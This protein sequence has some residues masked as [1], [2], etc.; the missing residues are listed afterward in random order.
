MHRTITV[1][2]VLALFLLTGCGGTEEK[3]EQPDS[4]PSA[5]KMFDK[6]K[7]PTP[8]VVPKGGDASKKSTAG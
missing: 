2:L 4:V 7:M 1:P 8:G 6:S 5:D 3:K